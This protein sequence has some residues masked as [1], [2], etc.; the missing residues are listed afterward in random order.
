MESKNL[1]FIPDKNDRSIDYGNGSTHMQMFKDSLE[2]SVSLNNC[3]SLNVN[4]L[5]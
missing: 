3:L 2:N 1:F 4:L 5:I